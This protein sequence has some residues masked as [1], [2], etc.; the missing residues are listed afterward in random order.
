[1]FLF[2]PLNAVEEPQ[3]SLDQIERMI[4]WTI[5]VL[6]RQK[7]NNSVRGPRSSGFQVVLCEDAATVM[8]KFF[9]E[10]RD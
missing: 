8:I 7:S 6:I 5:L 10:V 9:I 2:E 4:M 1:M 3:Y